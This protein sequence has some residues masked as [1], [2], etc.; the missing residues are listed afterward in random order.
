M[1]YIPKYIIKRMF[2]RKKC[3]SM[4]EYEGDEWV[5]LMMVN[6]ISPIEVPEGEI[7][8]GGID[9][10]NKVGEYIDIKVNDINVEATKEILLNDVILVTDGEVHT[11]E[12]IFED[13][14]AGGKTVPVGGKIELLIKKSAFPDEVKDLMEAGEEVEVSVHTTIDN[15]MD[16]TVKAIVQDAGEYSPE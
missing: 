13:G 3:L 4:V 12:S 9:L 8:L 15:P 5:K 11:W 7:D 2:P 10:P 1:S 14:S 16:I 6:V